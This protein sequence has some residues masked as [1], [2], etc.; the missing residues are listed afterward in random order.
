[1]LE[2]DIEKIL[3]IKDLDALARH[4]ANWDRETPHFNGRGPHRYAGG[5]DYC[6]Y[7]GK[8]RDYEPSV[9]L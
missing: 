4:R 7:C 8:P 5:E 2:R 3:D 1:M 9:K 6:C